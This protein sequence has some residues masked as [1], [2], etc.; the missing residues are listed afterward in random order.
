[1]QIYDILKQE[2]EEVKGL[3]NDLVALKKDDEYRFVLVEEIK[4]ALLPHSRAEEATFY[5]TLRAVDADK[6]IVAHGFQEH[7]EAES[8]LRLLEI[9]DKA[10]FDWQET[11]IK[12]RDALEHHIT[13][14]EGDIFSEARSMFSDDEAEAIGEAYLNLKP[15]FEGNGVVKSAVDLVVN[16]LP[17]R[18]ADSIRGTDSSKI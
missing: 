16:M 5:N 8:L 7:V 14:E 4:S 1:M 2:H 3:L 15:S 13:E 11:A 12:L 18:L 17:P 9:K 6:S 10:N